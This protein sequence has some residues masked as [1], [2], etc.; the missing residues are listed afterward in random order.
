MKQLVKQIKKL[1]EKIE[2]EVDR[3]DKW[4][5]GRSTKW[6]ESG[7]GIDYDENTRRLSDCS[8]SMNIEV[9]DKYT[10]MENEIKQENAE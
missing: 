4:S 1:K 9:A 2:A 10:K 5:E 3:R 7:K 6:K 8:F